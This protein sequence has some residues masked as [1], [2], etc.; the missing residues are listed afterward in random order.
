MFNREEKERIENKTTQVLNALRQAGED[1]LTNAELSRIAL[2]YGG[3]L[4][5]LYRD[6]YKID[7]VSLGNGL[8]NYILISEPETIVTR[9]K[10]IDKLF[11]AVNKRGFVD[12]ETLQRIMD[13][14]DITVRYKANTYK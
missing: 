4:G 8:Y 1:G 12:A 13:A 10:A 9:E 6:G 5:E 3:H 11:K 2:R 7:K 14:N